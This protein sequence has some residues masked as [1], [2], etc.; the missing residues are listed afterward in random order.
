MEDQDNVVNNPYNPDA[1]GEPQVFAVSRE[2]SGMKFTRRDFLVA[3]GAIAVV[4]TSGCST[5]P[6]VA[7]TATP[8]ATLSPVERE[9]ACESGQIWAHKDIVEQLMISPDGKL[10]ASA[11]LDKTIKLWS[12]PD[13]ILL[14]TLSKQAD[15]VSA[16]VFSPDSQLL[17]LGSWD[18]TVKLWSLPDGTLLHTLTETGG[19]VAISPDGK[20]LAS[21]GADNSVKLWSLPDAKLLKTLT[22][23]TSSV[24]AVAF[25]PTG[26]RLVSAGGYPD[27]TV[28]LWSLPDGALLGTLTPSIKVI[29]TL[30]FSRNGKQLLMAN[31][32]NNGI[33]LYSLPDGELISLAANYHALAISPDRQ[34][35]A[36]AKGDKTIE[37]WSMEKASRIS[38]LNANAGC[39]AIS[40][41]GKLLV[42]APDIELLASAPDMDKTIKLWSL[43]E[44]SLL[45]A[46]TAYTLSA[47]AVAISPDGKLLVSAGLDKAV[48]LW[49]LPEGAPITCM[50]DLATNAANVKGVAY[51]QKNAAGET[52]TYT[53]PCG[54]PIPAKAVCVCN[55]VAGGGCSCDNHSSGSYWYPN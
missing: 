25:S 6:V 47:E 18:S 39:M 2:G 20:M 30:V 9:K 24:F 54:S 42:S 13:R 48:K 17:A 32:S 38:M 55:C 36:F 52:V 15:S 27:E 14:C 31:N 29:Q 1:N 51:Q 12:L 33:G 45:R 4:G 40:P 5:A 49:S 16:L 50:I 28:K 19:G 34:W 10:L 43:P 7:P 11:S 41:D 37:L 8:Q 44:G 35:V 3:A 26:D 23:H 53:L 21:R 22:G 46:L